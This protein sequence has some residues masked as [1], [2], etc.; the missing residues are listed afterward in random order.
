MSYPIEVICVGEPDCYDDIIT[1]IGL[2]N[3]AQREFYFTV[4]PPRLQKSG[5][6]IQPRDDQ[7]YHSADV[8]AFLTKYREQS[9][10]Y[11]PFLIAVVEGK[12]RSDKLKNL[13]GN[14]DAR[15]GNAVVTMN[16]LE[17][18]SPSRLRYLCYYLIRYALSFVNPEIK[19]HEETRGCIFDKKMYKLDLAQSLDTGHICPDCKTQLTSR[20]SFE[21]NLAL[22]QILNVMRDPAE[23]PAADIAIITIVTEETIA[24]LQ[25][26]KPHGEARKTYGRKTVRYFYEGRLPAANGGV[27]RV[28]CTQSTKQGNRPVATAYTHITSEYSPK[29][30]VLLGIAGGI[31]KD[32]DVCDAM[33]ADSILYYDNRKVT[34]AG[35]RYRGQAYEISRWLLPEVNDFFVRY[36]EPAEFDAAEGSPN[37][38]FASSRGLS[39]LVKQLSPTRKG[40]SENGSQRPTTRLSP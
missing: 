11:R 15:N 35:T 39:V 24:V 8:F 7:G 5:W 10:G 40:R 19:S 21:E 2:L 1:A 29:L 25:G 31:R 26:L 23:K 6:D 37:A 17:L 33:I 32:I 3:D 9:R 27:H 12:L 16:D 22:Q 4:P 34:S 13:F 38:S 14:H 30:V 36:G 18:F 28:V 20:L